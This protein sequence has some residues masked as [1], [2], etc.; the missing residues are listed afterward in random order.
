MRNMAKSKYIHT[1]PRPSHLHKLLKFQ[2]VYFFFFLDLSI[3][4]QMA[5]FIL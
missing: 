1:E 3:E 2:A 4:K 5:W